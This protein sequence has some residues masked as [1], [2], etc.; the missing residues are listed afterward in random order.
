MS[1]PESGASPLD[2]NDTEVAFRGRSTGELKRAK[3]LFRSFNY[4]ALVSAGPKLAALAYGLRLP[5]TPLIRAAMFDYFC[6]GVTIEDCSR[7]VAQLGRYGVRA[8]LD[9]AVEALGD[10]AAFDR[11]AAELLAV[12]E[13]AKATSG[14]QFIAFKV[15]ALA[16]FDL[17]AK[18]S[19]PGARL[20][21][22]EK[23]ELARGESRIRRLC[24]AAR[25]GD[26]RLLVDAEESWIQPA[27]DRL[28]EAMMRAY[29]QERAVV[30]NTL[31]MYR[32]GRLAYLETLHKE[33]RAAGHRA[34]VKLV[35][36]A[37]LEKERARAA[38]FGAPSPVQ[39]DKPATDR[40]F[41][42]A[43]AYCVEHI[44]DLSLFAG[45]HNEASNRRLAELMAR[46]GLAR[47]DP[48][49][50]FSQLLGMSDNLTFNLAHH[51]YN[52][53]KYVPYGPVKAVLPYLGRRAAENS[54][55]RGQAGREL[56]LIERELERRRASR[57]A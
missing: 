55:I 47:H 49:V 56:E 18:A 21:L 45:S 7:T 28:A 40:D 37:Y 31:Q 20:T 39:P 1:K 53:S 14:T 50:E 41:D 16:R 26:R 10:E 22:E 42:Q 33:A 32:V 30:Y 48:R 54:S 13:R 52:V 43:L 5:V 15:T 27:I 23:A 17:L 29:N 2:F 38:A 36:G 11:T 44:D 9:Y 6:G 57:E 35:R 12:V 34:G 24:A 51:G 46:R 3:L 8:I 19:L 4:P 25:A